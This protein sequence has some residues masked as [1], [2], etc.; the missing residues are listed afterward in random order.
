MLARREQAYSEKSA[1]EKQIDEQSECIRA[2]E[3]Q[4]ERF[5]SSDTNENRAADAAAA[6]SSSSDS[7]HTLEHRLVQTEMQLAQCSSSLTALND[8]IHGLEMDHYSLIV[9][10]RRLENEALRFNSLPHGWS[11]SQRAKSLMQLSLTSSLASG[12]A[13]SATGAATVPQ[14]P[15]SP[16]TEDH[17]I[18]S[19][20][21]RPQQ[22]RARDK[23][24]A[25]TTFDRSQSMERSSDGGI[26]SQSS[27]DLAPHARDVVVTA[28]SPLATRLPTS[29]DSTPDESDEAVENDDDDEDVDRMYREVAD[30]RSNLPVCCRMHALRTHIAYEKATLMKNLEV[31]TEKRVLD[32]GIDRLQELQRRYVDLEMRLTKT[33]GSVDGCDDGKYAV[34]QKHQA[35]HQEELQQQ[36][37]LQQ[38][39]LQQQQLTGGSTPSTAPTLAMSRNA[40]NVCVTRSMQSIGK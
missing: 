31:N 29:D 6:G 18:G 14:T 26:S 33:A 25:M 32:E 8:E 36:Q 12:G 9:T 11:A 21:K 22:Q 16:M 3:S 38:Q 7:L 13:H 17:A 10:R 2:I 23:A 35:Q 30:A 40:S 1:L 27:A 5:N 4:L 39:Q 34:C 24:A 20:P 37:R 19:G 15:T 28:Q